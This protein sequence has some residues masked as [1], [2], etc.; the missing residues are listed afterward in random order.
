MNNWD[1]TV[2]WVLS[3]N[4]Q[5]IVPTSLKSEL[6]EIVQAQALGSSLRLLS[7]FSSDLVGSPQR[8]RTPHITDEYAASV[9]DAPRDIIKII[10]ATTL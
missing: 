9:L 8:P 4:V 1:H 3:V 5:V 10:S 7:G 2:H 6:V